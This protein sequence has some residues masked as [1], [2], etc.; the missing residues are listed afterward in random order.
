V[1]VTNHPCGQKSFQINLITYMVPSY[2]LIRLAGSGLTA[3]T[4]LNFWRV[5][6]CYPIRCCLL[7]QLIHPQI[8]CCPSVPS[9]A[10]CASDN[11]KHSRSCKYQ[12]EAA[13]DVLSVTLTDVTREQ[14]ASCNCEASCQA[15]PCHSTS[16][17]ACALHDACKGGQG[18]RG[19]LELMRP[20]RTRACP[21]MEGKR[22]LGC[23]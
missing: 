20:G 18:V 8:F 22:P 12:E 23:D 16:C 19:M 21:S 3:I 7:H 13:A 15:M 5:I 2:S 1:H 4:R 11:V 9:A 17:H 6:R 10:V 14:A